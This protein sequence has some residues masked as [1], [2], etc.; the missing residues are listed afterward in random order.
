MLFEERIEATI[1]CAQMTVGLDTP[2]TKNAQ[3]Y[4]TNEKPALLKAG[5]FSDQQ[6]SPFSFYKILLGITTGKKHFKVG[7]DN[8]F[9]HDSKAVQCK[10]KDRPGDH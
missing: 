7:T 4:S 6:R 5:R 10:R 2:F 8:T 1:L 3:G 9:F